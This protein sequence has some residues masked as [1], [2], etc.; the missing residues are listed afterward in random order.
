MVVYY[1]EGCG[2]EIQNNEESIGMES[3]CSQCGQVNIVPDL[4][5]GGGRSNYAGFWK[6][7]AAI[8]IDS[9]I[10]AL[11][12]GLI[13][14]IFGAIT[15]GVLGVAGVDLSVIQTICGAIGF[16]LGFI[17]RWLYYTLLE[18]S[19]KQATV[20]KM[21]LGII[22]ADGQGNKIS[23]ARANGRYWAKIISGL[24]LY[25]GF[26]MAGYTKR[27][28]ALHDIIAGSFVINKQ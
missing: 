20:G 4:G 2:S 12:G 3:K 14:G 10:L 27:K 6:R 15:G 21:V 11:A 23:F 5:N 7:F 24:I 9:I 19:S 22:V 18:C 8:L 26:I 25:I 16:V 1:C 17:L 28:Q 13:G